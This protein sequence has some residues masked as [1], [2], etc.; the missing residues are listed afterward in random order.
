MQTYAIRRRDG[1]ASVEDLQQAAE[2]SKRI[3]EEMTDDVR[4]IRSYVVAEESGGLGTV[5][6]YQATGPEALHRHADRARLPI[7]EV[8]P[9][10]D[11]VVVRPD[12]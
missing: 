7:N 3:G 9:V 1:F 2:R 8:V 11:V 4:W 10:V 12:P 5:C 6:I